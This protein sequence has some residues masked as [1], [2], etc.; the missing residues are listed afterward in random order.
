MSLR[1]K[2]SS[3]IRILRWNRDVSARASHLV[4]V[5]NFQAG[6]GNVSGSTFSERKNMSTK[7]SFKRIA[8]VAAVALALGG[9]SAVSAN[10]AFGTLSNG[11][12]TG[13]TNPTTATIGNPVSIAV[14][15]TATA[16][17]AADALTLTAT[18]TSASTGAVVVSSLTAGSLIVAQTSLTNV[19][20]TTAVTAATSAITSVAA[21]AAGAAAVVNTYTFTPDVPGVYTLHF[22]DGTNVS[23]YAVTASATAPKFLNHTQDPNVIGVTSST[24][25]ALTAITGGFATASIEAGVITSKHYITVTGGTPTAV[26]VNGSSAPGS[27]INSS[28]AASTTVTSSLIWTPVN[29]TDALELTVY[30]PTAGVATITDTPVVV[31]TGV[32]ATAVSGTITFG[33]A[34]VVSAQYSSAYIGAGTSAATSTTDVVPVIASKGAANTTVVANIQVTLKSDSTNGINGQGISASVSGPGTLSIATGTTVSA[35]AVGRSLSIA[36]TANAGNT[37]VIGVFAD[38]TSGVSTITITSGTTVI[39]TKTVTFYGSASKATATQALYVAKAGTALGANP[40]N[41]LLAGAVVGNGTTDPGAETLTSGT[42]AI[43]AT[44]VDSNGNPAAGATVKLVSS[45]STVITAG[46]CLEVTLGADAAPG[47]WQCQVSGAANAVSGK[48]ATVTF[49]VYNS[50]TAAYDI[51]ATPLTFTIGGSVKTVALSTD[52]SSY[53]SLAPIKLVATAKDSSGNL[54]Y[55]QDY[56]LFAATLTSSTYLGGGTLPGATAVTLINGIHTYKGLYAPATAGDFIISGLDGTVAM[57]AVSVTATAGGT[58]ADASSQA[59]T[60]AAQEATD[61]AN[62]AYDAANNAMDSADAATAAA[63][64]ASDNASAALAAVTSLSATV[65]KLVSSVTAIAT[66]LAAIKKKLGVK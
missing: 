49:E 4:E 32:P 10:A 38:G 26:A 9:F 48:S 6:S 5:F 44:V 42:P 29:A 47:T 64:D 35:V 3:A 21:V 31:A 11:A 12:A 14:Q 62:A 57:N 18:L 28:G 37:D 55:D 8:A 2:V 17:A 54:A 30:S 22:T 41:Y 24:G 19:T 63:Q 66:A 39:A 60:D 53:N 25:N 40:S 23:T 15:E 56:A 61:A 52:A 43:T 16:A 59:A 36:G 58:S 33:A 65:A 27:V 13:I 20:A 46:G 50:T 34:P 1:Q 51:L 45:D 7:T